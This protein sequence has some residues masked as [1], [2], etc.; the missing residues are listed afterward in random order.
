MYELQTPPRSHVAV[1]HADALLD[2]GFGYEWVV[3]VVVRR[4]WPRKLEND[5]ESRLE[6]G[7]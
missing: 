2:A 6:G 7:G 1:E 5:F 3:M 4:A